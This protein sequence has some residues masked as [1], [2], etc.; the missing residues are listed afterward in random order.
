LEFNQRLLVSVGLLALFTSFTLPILRMTLFGD[1]STSILGM[2]RTLTYGPGDDVIADQ[3][4][5]AAS[6]DTMV[7][8]AL[9]LP[10]TVLPLVVIG[11]LYSLKKPSPGRWLLIVSGAVGLVGSVSLL[12]AVEL[13]KNSVGSILTLATG[14][15]A[16]IIPT[17]VRAD[18]A[19]Y[20]G[21][22]GSFILVVSGSMMSARKVTPPAESR[23]AESEAQSVAE[24]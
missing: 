17:S 15:L 2:Y 1:L 8:L 10:L 6:A 5:T 24:S 18:T 11:G 13:V 23:P 9:Y 19:P 16:V 22:I 7:A 3:M 12:V 21:I 14:E 20:M 4:I